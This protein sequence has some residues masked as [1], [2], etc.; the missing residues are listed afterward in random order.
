MPYIYKPITA[1][2]ARNIRVNTGCLLPVNTQYE[3]E[4]VLEIAIEQQKLMK[5]MNELD[6]ELKHLAGE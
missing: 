6:I 3:N 5:K 4:R 2:E 1:K